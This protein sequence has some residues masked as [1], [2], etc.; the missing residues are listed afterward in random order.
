[1]GE[2]RQHAV[3]V[4]FV[5]FVWSAEL[6][7]KNKGRFRPVSRDVHTRSVVGFLFF[8]AK[9]DRPCF[10]VLSQSVSGCLCVLFS[11]HPLPNSLARSASIQP[12]DVSNRTVKARPIDLLLLVSFHFLKA[13]GGYNRRVCMPTKVLFKCLRWCCRISY[14]GYG[15]TFG[16]R[17]T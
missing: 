13:V 7:Q 2:I 9:L 10:F 8:C 16:L 3:K 14:Q 1:M 11:H 15:C 6:K 4:C 5:F 12:R 17:V